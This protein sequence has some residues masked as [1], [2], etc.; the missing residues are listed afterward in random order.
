MSPP[1]LFLKYRPVTRGA[2]T[3]PPRLIRR[4]TKLRFWFTTAM[5]RGVT[6]E[7]EQGSGLYQYHPLLNIKGVQS[8]IN[9][10]ETYSQVNVKILWT[11]SKVI[12]KSLKYSTSYTST[13]DGVSKN[14]RC[15]M[16]L[17]FLCDSM[18]VNLERAQRSW[19]RWWVQAPRPS[20][21]LLRPSY[22]SSLQ[23]EA[24]SHPELL[25]ERIINLQITAHTKES[26]KSPYTEVSDHSPAS[27]LSK[28]LVDA[29]LR[30]FLMQPTLFFLAA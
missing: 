18:I 8:T 25:Q 26:F 4:W 2:A 20:G 19:A 6:P 14:I 23:H 30:S 17:S 3:S 1:I 16:C 11:T 9:L 29:Q 13:L 12:F 28:M 27:P 7:T 22:H 21:P 24:P 10:K 15:M 5:W